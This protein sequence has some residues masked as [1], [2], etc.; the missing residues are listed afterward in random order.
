MGGPAAARQDGD[1]GE[2]EIQGA[3][4]AEWGEG[5]ETE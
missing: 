5:G 1:G 3:T 2:G 4:G